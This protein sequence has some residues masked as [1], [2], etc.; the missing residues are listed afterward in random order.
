MELIRINENKK[1]ISA[2]SLILMLV[3]TL[4]MAIA[5]SSLGQVGVPQ[6]V[7]TVGYISVAPTIIGVDQEATVNLWVFPMPTN[8][9][10]QPYFKGFTGVTVTFTKPDGSK[11]SFMPIDGTGQF[12][13]GQTESLG[14]I[15]FYY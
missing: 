15:Y 14:S 4:M 7:K 11:D 8:Y 9:M 3:M 10:Y 1:K 6:P 13:A 12:V 5:Q 2:L